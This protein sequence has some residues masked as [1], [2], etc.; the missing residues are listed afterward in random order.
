MAGGIR[1]SVTNGSSFASAPSTRSSV[2]WTLI[3]AHGWR[4][5]IWS[6]VSNDSAFAQPNKIAN[7]IKLRLAHDLNE[8]STAFLHCARQLPLHTTTKPSNHKFRI[9]LLPKEATMPQVTFE[10]PLYQTRY[11]MPTNVSA[12]TPSPSVLLI[13]ANI[14]CSPG[15]E[16]DHPTKSTGTANS[17]EFG[18][19]SEPHASESKTAQQTWNTP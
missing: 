6:N 16:T 14:L 1:S 8:L 13:Q 15:V 10:T 19:G 7:M 11:R 9:P 18:T 3:D 2:P 5:P 17:S 12:P 4:H